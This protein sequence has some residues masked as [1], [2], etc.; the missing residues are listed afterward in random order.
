MIRRRA[1]DRRRHRVL[2]GN[3]L[4]FVRRVSHR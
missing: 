2:N 1:Y 3:A 4:Q